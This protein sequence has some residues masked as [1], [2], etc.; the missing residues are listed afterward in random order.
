MGFFFVRKCLFLVCV[1]FYGFGMFNIFGR[2]FFSDVLII[3]FIVRGSSLNHIMTNDVYPMTSLWIVFLQATD[4][5]S[6][7][8][9]Q[10]LRLLQGS[11]SSSTIVQCLQNQLQKP[12]PS[13]YI[14]YTVSI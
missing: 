13:L 10:I 4:Y 9:I 2:H 3:A 7:G 5:I 11:I 1:Q 8:G 12:L 6:V 14:Y